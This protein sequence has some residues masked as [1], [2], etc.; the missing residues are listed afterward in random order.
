M[1]LTEIQHELIFE[2]DRYFSEC[3]AS[4]ILKFGDKLFCAYF[5][6]TK[7]G[8]DDVRIYLS[9]NENGEWKEPKQMTFTDGIPCWNP[10]LF[11]YNGT[12]ILFYKVGKKIPEWQTYYMTSADGENWTEPKELVEGDTSGGRGPVK[13]KAIL[14]SDGR[15]IAP[16]SVETKLKWDAFTDVSADGGKTWQKS[17]L[18]GFNH[19]IAKGKGIIQPTLWESD[20][21]IYALLRSTEGRILKSVSADGLNWSKCEKTELANNNSGIDCVKL[22]DGSVIVIH[23]PI[24][25]DWGDR[26]IISY[27]ITSDNAESFTEPVTIEKDENTQAEFSYPAVITDTEYLYVTY[28]HYRKSVMFRKYKIEF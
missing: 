19:L 21:R 20:G 18:M 14:L 9:V 12:I 10:V 28:T 8:K 4:T 25:A 1:K 3:H 11:E 2:K 27:A 24:S 15:I 6:G 26:N 7:E 22:K 13:N 5:A 23:N 17:G 16:A